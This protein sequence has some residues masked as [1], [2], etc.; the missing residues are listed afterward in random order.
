GDVAAGTGAN[1]DQIE[2][3]DV[4]HGR[5]RVGVCSVALRQSGFAGGHSGRP[6]TRIRCRNLG[7]AWTR[8]QWAAEPLAHPVQQ[9]KPRAVRTTR[10]G[11]PVALRGR[12]S[13]ASTLHGPPPFAAMTRKMKQNSTAVSPWFSIG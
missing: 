5:T 1:H 3:F 13:M 9:R 10:H 8:C 4:G 12:R 6:P 7:T 11:D 2:V